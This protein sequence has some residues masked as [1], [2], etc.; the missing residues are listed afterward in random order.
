[1]ITNFKLYEDIDAELLEDVY[2]KDNFLIDCKETGE[3]IAVIYFTSHALFGDNTREKLIED[4]LRKNRFEW[5]KIRINRARKHIFV[6]DVLKQFYKYGINSKINSIDKLIDFLKIQT[7]G[8]RVITIGGSAGG[9]MALLVGMFLNAEMIFAFSPI[10]KLPSGWGKYDDLVPMLKKN[11]SFILY[12]TPEYSKNDIEQL[13]YLK[14]YKYKNLH[15]Y[16]Y[17]SDIHGETMKRK[18]CKG[19]I[20]SSPKLLSFIDKYFL[21]NKPHKRLI[22]FIFGLCY[23]KY[24]IKR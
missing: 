10:I 11:S 20:N 9:Y 16:H 4:L 21:K 8:M 17:K 1:M 2:S 13:S 7:E 24:L 3:N 22:Q 5:Y 19:L 18:G 6:R 23:L 12:F 14:D 15:I